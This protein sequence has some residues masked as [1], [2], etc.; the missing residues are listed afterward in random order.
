M[1]STERIFLSFRSSTSHSKAYFNVILGVGRLLFTA[2]LPCWPIYC[3]CVFLLTEFC[4]YFCA[5]ATLSLASQQFRLRIN[6][7]ILD[8]LDLCRIGDGKSDKVHRYRWQAQRM[9]NNNK[10]M[11][12]TRLHKK[13]HAEWQRM[14]RT[15][16]KVIILIHRRPS[17]PSQM[18]FSFF[19]CFSFRNA[20]T[21]LKRGERILYSD[22]L[23]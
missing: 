18:L 8:S 5:M 20:K 19:N 17:T 2:C 15:Q 10:L 22:G 16:T 21:F 3:V 11:M 7:K 6:R 1:H 23:S 13:D 14:N 4:V 12:C 9:L